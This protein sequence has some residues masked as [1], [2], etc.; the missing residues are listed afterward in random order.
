MHMEIDDDDYLPS[1][2]NDINNKK[3]KYRND[4]ISLVENWNS[5][6]EIIF[7][8]IIESQGFSENSLCIKCKKT[9]FLRCLDC[10]PN[11]YFCYECDTYFHNII[12]IFHR[13]ITKD[14]EINNFTKIIKLPQICLG[15][16][17]HEI[18]KVLCIDI[19]GIINFY[20]FY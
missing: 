17:N 3:Q 4:Q 11:I 19:K 7:N 9:A 12:N 15:K 6:T 5:I 20:V 14:D 16:C 18:F 13:R 8:G 2:Y 10:G 1:F